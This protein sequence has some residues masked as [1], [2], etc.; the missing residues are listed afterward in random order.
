VSDAI[1]VALIGATA[2]IVGPVVL[3]LLTN[4]RHRETK[5]LLAENTGKTG[6]VLH[7]VKNDHDT[8]L[9]EELDARFSGLH[10]K[11]SGVEAAQARLGGTVGRLGRS[12]DEALRH[13]R[14]HDA[15]SVL[16]VD[17]LHRRDA[18][19]A[20]EIRRLKQGDPPPG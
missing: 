7:Q 16:A 6:E 5:Q 9:R 15:A 11:L 2:S 13:Q 12:V 18:E 20:E 19:L 10:D 8:N 3:L 17:R 4:R 1:T 14:E